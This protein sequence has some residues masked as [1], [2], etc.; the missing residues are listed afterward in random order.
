MGVELMAGHDVIAVEVNDGKVRVVCSCDWKS[1][2]TD[3]ANGEIAPRVEWA[4]HA[5]VER[6][7]FGP[8][9]EDE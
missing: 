3:D 4:E 8:H 6:E 1:G 5:G 7:D 9:A 2:W